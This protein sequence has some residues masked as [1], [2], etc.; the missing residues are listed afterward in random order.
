MSPEGSD[1]EASDG[2]SS[3]DEGS[4]ASAAPQQSDAGRHSLRLFKGGVGAAV[5]VWMLLTRLPRACSLA[6]L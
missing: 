1:G 2:S 6:R 5:L 3:V 4:E